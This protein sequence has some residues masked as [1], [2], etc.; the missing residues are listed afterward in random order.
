MILLVKIR[1][2]VTPMWKTMSYV[3]NC[4]IQY[5]PFD[6]CVPGPQTKRRPEKGGKLNTSQAGSVAASRAAV[7]QFLSISREAF[8]LRTRY[9]S[10][11]QNFPNFS[12]LK[13]SHTREMTNFSI[14]VALRWTCTLKIRFPGFCLGWQMLKN[15]CLQFKV[16]VLFCF[17]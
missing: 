13:T 17:T 1:I 9:I 7:D 3:T 12:W 8:I 4:Q 16:A 5:V 6:K 14:M 11:L 2:I 15:L 10:R